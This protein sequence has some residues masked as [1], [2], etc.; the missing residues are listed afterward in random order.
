MITRREFIRRAG[1]A[2]AAGSIGRISSVLAQEPAPET[3]RIRI[4]AS[5][6]LCFAPQFVA[7]ELLRAEGFTQIEFVSRDNLPSGPLLGQGYA[8]ISMGLAPSL[9][10]QVDSGQALVILGGGH[11]GC[12]E[13][14]ATR[15]VRSVKELK[16]KEIAI[17]RRGNGAHVFLSMML[18]YVGVD[19]NRDVHWKEVPHWPDTVRLLAESKVDAFLGFP[20][21]P[22]ELR[23]KRIG[24]VILNTATERPWSQ[25]YCCMVAA[26]REFA[27]S[28]P[29]ATR[30]A[31]RAILKG[32]DLC[33]AEPDRAA[34]LL[35]AKIP[36]ADPMHVG[37]MF[38]ELP[39]A[40][41]RTLSPEDSLRFY[42]LRLHEIG[43]VKSN[44]QRLIAQG[45]DWRFLNELRKELK[46]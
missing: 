4:A 43:M 42:A 45:T 31:L 29:V 44:P 3:R 2:S 30:R 28:N 34:Q 22:Q 41:W 1:L 20:P 24:R 6:A 37:Q 21:E 8:D 11:A 46:A 17:A 16:G 33:H 35:L 36:G 26:N 38:R 14:V 27:R 25:Y 5:T 12:Y 9:L 18:A 7:E 15:G 40:S 32:S 23:A 13:L 10:Q 19:P 39:Y